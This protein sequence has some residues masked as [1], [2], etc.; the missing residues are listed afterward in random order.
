MSTCGTCKWWINERIEGFAEC[1]YGL[2]NAPSSHRGND[3]MYKDEGSDCPCWKPA[4][5]EER[6][7]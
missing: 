4:K 2:D 5:E 7:S 1:G 6:Q 3:P